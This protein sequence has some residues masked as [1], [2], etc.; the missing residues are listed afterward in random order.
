MITLSNT[1]IESVDLLMYANNI[2]L[3]VQSEH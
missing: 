1:V 3:S 2:L